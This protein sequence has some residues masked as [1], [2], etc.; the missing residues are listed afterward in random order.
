[1][2]KDLKLFTSILLFISYTFTLLATPPTF[3]TDSALTSEEITA[4]IKTPELQAVLEASID[5]QYQKVTKA[6]FLELSNLARN[7]K[8]MHGF[9]NKLYGP[10]SNLTADDRS[11]LKEVFKDTPAPKVIT[12][13]N[14]IKV[15][16]QGQPFD[17]ELG[18]ALGSVLMNSKPAEN[19]DLSNGVR[20]AVES[21]M[22]EARLHF[23]TSPSFA[24]L[25]HIP[26]AQAVVPLVVVVAGTVL[27]DAVISSAIGAVAGAVVGSVTGCA[28]GVHY[29]GDDKTYIEGCKKGMASATGVGG[30][31][32]AGNAALGGFTGGFLSTWE[33]DSRGVVNMAGL[34]QIQ[35]DEIPKIR[36]FIKVGGV[37]GALAAAYHPAISIAEGYGVKLECFV[38][39]RWQLS[40]MHAGKQGAKLATND[41]LSAKNE[42]QK[43]YEKMLTEK[44]VPENART[45]LLKQ[46]MKEHNK[47]TEFC[48]KNPGLTDSAIFSDIKS[49]TEKRIPKSELQGVR[50]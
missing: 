1:M 37:L 28:F 34:R 40:S 22:K 46:I 31:I 18:S 6:W 43:Q 29:K 49:A 38:D 20:A 41:G 44:G 7:E 23:R 14:G 32:G 12:T 36:N 42:T 39:G 17:F 13:K 21:S 30:L 26:Q 33:G 50:K 9:F 8:S 25:T 45:A 3:A 4:I 2:I 27:R 16:I 47:H 48:K 11:Y 24:L 15:S 5:K 19:V 35:P 10:D